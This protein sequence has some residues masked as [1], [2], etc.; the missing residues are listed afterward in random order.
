MS[1]DLRGEREE[2]GGLS[3]TSI[4]SGKPQKLFARFI[5][6]GAFSPL[7]PPK[8]FAHPLTKIPYKTPGNERLVVFTI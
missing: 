3:T 7:T 2:R 8:S 5:N 1:K 6:L 4:D